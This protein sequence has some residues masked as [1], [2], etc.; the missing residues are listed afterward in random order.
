MS[1]T[2]S[3]HSGTGP[4]RQELTA[5]AIFL[6]RLPVRF[7]GAMPA[8]LHGRALGWYPVIGAL[9]GLCGALVY[10][11]GT[12]VGLTS[13]AAALLA[14]GVQTA[15]TGALHEDGLADVTDGFG[16]GRDKMAKLEIMRDSRVGSYGV[17]ALIFSVGLRWSALVALADPLAVGLAL[18]SAGALSRA[19]VPAV[20]GW[21]DPA[22][23]DGLA[24]G[25]G[26]PPGL[27]IVM[28]AI[29]GVCISGLLLS[30]TALP[31][32]AVAIM[33]GLAFGLVAFRQIGGHT[34]DVLGACQ[35]VVEVAVL[36]TL[37]IL[38]WMP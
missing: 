34:G 1:E 30:A 28:A 10:I 32:I 24:V 7:D 27:R 21:L 22:R 35:Q 12:F 3:T 20:Y 6:T 25:L 15:V 33:A 16:G 11:A 18:I 37:V 38:P 9:I 8:D 17:L 23:N 5:A 13:D 2:Q 14:L 26:R 19:V 31:V 36:L 4:L 29:L